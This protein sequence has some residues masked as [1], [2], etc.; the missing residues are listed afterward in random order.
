MVTFIDPAYQYAGFLA[1]RSIEKPSGGR[2]PAFRFVQSSRGD[3]ETAA[4]ASNGSWS[5]SA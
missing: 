1:G 4:S 5:K 3:P 2:K